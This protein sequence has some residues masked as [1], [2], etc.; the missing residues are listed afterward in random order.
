[1]K[2]SQSQSIISSNP[3]YTENSHISLLP[4]PNSKK[5]TI[6]I[7]TAKAKRMVQSSSVGLLTLFSEPLSLRTKSRF[8]D[9][10][11]SQSSSACPRSKIWHAFK[12]RGGTQTPRDG[13]GRH[14]DLVGVKITGDWWASAFIAAYGSAI[15]WEASL[16]QG[17]MVLLV[18]DPV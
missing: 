17:G 12:C 5:P 13:W 3:T 7:V 14:F 4:Q 16:T 15:I 8:H 10:S 9:P 1:M 11:R 6:G 18:G 2:P